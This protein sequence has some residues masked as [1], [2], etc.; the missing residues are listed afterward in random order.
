M[1]NVRT[2]PGSEKKRPAGGP[3]VRKAR[4]RLHEGPARACKMPAQIGHYASLR[5]LPLFLVSAQ[6]ELS[7]NCTVM[8]DTGAASGRAFISYVREDA[9]KAEELQDLVAAAGVP[10]QRPGTPAPAV[11]AC[12][13]PAAQARSGPATRG[14]AGQARP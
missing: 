1:H 3:R 9:A 12:H 7:Y 5:W 10:W 13:G 14:I 8:A 2:D 6:A 4:V 11:A